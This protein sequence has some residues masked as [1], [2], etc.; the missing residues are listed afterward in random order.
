MGRQSYSIDTIFDNRPT[1][2]TYSQ[3]D[4]EVK[5]FVD[6]VIKDSIKPNK[7]L[8]LN[9]KELQPKQDD[10]W[11]LTWSDIIE[12][13][14]EVKDM[15]MVEAMKIVYGVSDKDF[16]HLDIFNCFAVYKWMT[17]QL[18]GIGEIEL[19]ELGHEPTM[20]EKNAGVESLNEFGY[21]L[22]LKSLTKGDKTKDAYYLGLTYAEIFR[23]MCMDKRISEVQQNMIKNARR[24]TK[25][26]Y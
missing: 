17:E 24:K 12:L 6:D 7:V 19:Q 4:E 2:E 14:E 3:L 13:R 5:A 20:E 11:Q 10:F 22:S 1:V 23:E 25:R 21:A 16:S 26:S 9:G 18:K 15:N 8:R